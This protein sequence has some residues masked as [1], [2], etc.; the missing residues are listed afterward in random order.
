MKYSKQ[1]GLTLIELMV[2]LLISLLIMAG[3]FTVY[4][5]NQRGFRLNDGLTRVQENGRFALDFLSRDIRQAG[6]PSRDPNSNVVFPPEF[7]FFLFTGGLNDAAVVGNPNTSDTLSLRHGM[8]GSLTTDC[9]GAFPVPGDPTQGNSDG[10]IDLNQNGKIWS[11]DGNTTLNVYDI[12]DTGRTNNRGLPVFALFCN[13]NEMV[14]G[15]ENMQ[16][17]YGVD[18]DP[19]PTTR[20]YV[21]NQYYTF[22]LI[23]DLDGDGVTDWGNIVSLRIALLASSVDE[24]TNTPSPRTF[25]LLDINI[26]AFA[27]QKIR[28]VYTTTIL[29]RNNMAL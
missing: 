21:A 6:F 2:A 20:D 12:Q 15:I 5:S 26:P 3:L 25:R 29:L 13:G 1:Q 8:F 22:N 23:P 28:R 19:N 24:K 27:D 11:S 4:Q 16:V 9:A 14:E 17:L 7:Q 10:L 18:T